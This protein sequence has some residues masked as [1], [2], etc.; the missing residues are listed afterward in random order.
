MIYYRIKISVE[1]VEAPAGGDKEEVVVGPET[2]HSSEDCTQ[3][4]GIYNKIVAL[5][6][7]LIEVGFQS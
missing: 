7:S 1:R 2:L 4:W 5:V 6:R 3:V